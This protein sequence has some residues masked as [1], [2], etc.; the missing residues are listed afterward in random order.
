MRVFWLMLHVQYLI[1]ILTIDLGLILVYSTP[2]TYPAGEVMEV[3]NIRLLS[4]YTW[5]FSR[6]LV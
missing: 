5:F 2:V 1:L 4:P 6:L 3:F